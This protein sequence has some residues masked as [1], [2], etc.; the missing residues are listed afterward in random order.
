MEVNDV[1]PKEPMSAPEV[2]QRRSRKR[3]IIVFVTVCV[4][5]AAL[6]VLM[7]TQLLTPASNANQADTTTNNAAAVVGDVHSP[8]LGKPM[9]DFT[10]SQFGSKATVHLAALKGK[11][12]VLNFWASWC[13]PCNQEAPFLEKSWAGLQKQGVVFVGIDGPEANGAAFLKQYSISYPNVQDTINGATGIDY[14]V[15]SFPETVFINRDGIV[16]A[17]WFGPLNEAGLQFEMSKL[18]R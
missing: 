11:P 17:K 14:G 8:L 6:L 2:I 9:P 1:A 7:A 3:S 16:K 12:I 18:M 10:L 15:T 13:D 5:S 4:L